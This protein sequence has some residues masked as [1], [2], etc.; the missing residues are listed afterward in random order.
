MDS[1]DR[2][3]H[4]VFDSIRDNMSM[5]KLDMIFERLQFLH[6]QANQFMKH[7]G[8]M[9]QQEIEA[10]FKHIKGIYPSATMVFQTKMRTEAL[11]KSQMNPKILMMKKNE[12]IDRNNSMKNTYDNFRSTNPRMRREAVQ[13][14]E[15]LRDPFAKIKH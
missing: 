8:K 2:L 1:I 3:P 12:R 9:R 7:E 4:D 15:R 5:K 13:F 6:K 14:L 10:T 11:K